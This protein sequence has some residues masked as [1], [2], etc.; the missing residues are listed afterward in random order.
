MVP[1]EVPPEGVAIGLDGF[2]PVLY[3]PE[4]G[5]GGGPEAWMIAHNGYTSMQAPRVSCVNLNIGQLCGDPKGAPTTWPKPLNTQAGPLGSGNTGDLATTQVPQFI[6]PSGFW[7]PLFYPAVTRRGLP[8]FPNGSVGVGCLNMDEHRNCSYTPLAALT[9]APGRSNVNGLTG[10]VQAGNRIYGTA[11][12]GRELC[13]E[14]SEDGMTTSACPGQPY[15]TDTPPNNDVAGLGPS[16]FHGT[17]A[18]VDGRIYTTSN[19]GAASARTTSPHLPTLTCFDP[20]TNTTCRLWTPK[21]ITEPGAYEAL[22]ITGRYDTAA[23][24]TGVCAIAGNTTIAAPIVTC[25]DRDGKTAPPPPGLRDLFPTGGARSVVFQPLTTTVNGDLRTYL[26]FY[27][28]DRTHLGS[29]LCYS[30]N[31]Q[32]PCQ[33]FPG[34]LAHPDVNGGG[35]HDRGYSYTPVNGCMYGNGGRGLLFSFDPTSGTP[36]C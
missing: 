2:T 20:T 21:K 26:P 33:G 23:T 25:Y 34:P 11:T 35:S 18:V 30:W 36:G 31:E 4:P 32:A 29:A 24:A 12:N 5:G 17:K 1:A 10:F 13:A 6:A 8:G 28:E 7:Q 15:S 3:E 27:T 9:D 19:S 14:V 16:D 22:A